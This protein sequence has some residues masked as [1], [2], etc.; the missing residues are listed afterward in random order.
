MLTKYDMRYF[1]YILRELARFVY[2]YYAW[3][4]FIFFLIP[5]LYF[6]NI[7]EESRGI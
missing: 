1:L 3:F 6:Y 2:F 5:D 7:S 4:F